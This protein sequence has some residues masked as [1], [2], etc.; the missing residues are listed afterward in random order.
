MLPPKKPLNRNVCIRFVLIN[1]LVLSFLV[2]LFIGL[3]ESEATSWMLN[4]FGVWGTDIIYFAV[5]IPAIAIGLLPSWI[6]GIRW[7]KTHTRYQ[8]W[9][10][11]HCITCNY[12]LRAHLPNQKCPECGTLIPDSHGTIPP[13]T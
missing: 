13:T 6:F 5:G 4:R 8:R 1:V 11:N 2:V 9:K 3:F 12:D 7:W 10:N